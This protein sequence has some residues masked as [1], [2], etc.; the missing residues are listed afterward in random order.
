MYKCK[1]SDKG[2]TIIEVIIAMSIFSF[3]IFMGYRVMNGVIDIT[4]KQSTITKEQQSANLVNKYIT[5]DLKKSDI[6]QFRELS[7]LELKSNYYSYEIGDIGYHITKNEKE[8]TYTLKRIEHLGNEI[9]IIKNQSI[10]YDVIPFEIN[11]KNENMYTVKVAYSS[12]NNVFSFDIS[13]RTTVAHNIDNS[14]NWDGQI[15]I[16]Q[17]GGSKL[18]MTNEKNEK[19]VHNKGKG[20][21]KLI[22]DYENEKIIVDD[23]ILGTISRKNSISEIDI[24]KLDGDN[25]NNYNLKNVSID[26][27]IKEWKDD[28]NGSFVYRGRGKVEKLKKISVEFSEFKNTEMSININ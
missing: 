6:S 9:E 18:E 5:E 1:N 19:Y 15:N 12:E 8:K 16:Y 13:P 26:S 24:V 21:F 14:M 3:I 4:S 25:G 11:K 20:E 27:T 28:Y 7:E 23:I 22:L 2:F 17:H 10:N